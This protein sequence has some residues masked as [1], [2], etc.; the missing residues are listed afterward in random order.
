[1]EKEDDV[2]FLPSLK[3]SFPAVP[4]KANEK[5]KPLTND[6]KQQNMIYMKCA[7][8]LWNSIKMELQI[9]LDEVSMYL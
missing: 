2:F 5:T 3:Y 6:Q 4:K 8:K 1:M 7:K 9:K